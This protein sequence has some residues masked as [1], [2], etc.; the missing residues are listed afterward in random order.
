MALFGFSRLL[1]KNA[2]NFIPLD[3]S[4][5][6]A[7]GRPIYIDQD[8]SRK[9]SGIEQSHITMIL[10]KLKQLGATAAGISSH[11]SV[12]DAHEHMAIIG[13]VR[14]NYKMFQN[15]NEQGKKAGVYITDVDTGSFADGEPGLR[16]VKYTKGVWEL[17]DNS[18]SIIETQY[19]AINGMC[20]DAQQAATEILPDMLKEAYK[21]KKWEGNLQ[22]DGYNMFYNPPSLYTKGIRFKT[23]KQKKT[24]LNATADLLKDTFIQAQTNSKK[25]HW[26]V[27]SDGARLFGK[28]LTKMAGKDLSNHTV[29]FCAPMEDVSD[30]IPKMKQCNINLHD[31]VMKIADDDWRSRRMQMGSGPKI[32]DALKDYPGLNNAN[33]QAKLLARSARKDLLS[34]TGDAMSAG[35][36]GVGIGALCVTGFV[37]AP[38]TGGL[39]LSGVIAGGLGAVAKVKKAEALRNAAATNIKSPGLNP[40]MHPFKS[41]EQMNVHMEEHSGGFVKTFTDVLKA[42]F[43]RG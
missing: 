3:S 33:T 40:H 14:V 28:A 38:L 16:S 26:V 34:I 39:S 18:S 20:R 37:T 27:H 13:S 21:D 30:L 25:V 29:L 19:A 23:P 5:N 42:K 32:R 7:C 8:L 9:F 11:S 12:S 43:S 41:T 10:Q 2:D 15:T 36:I 6:G 31:D 24:S 1:G 35:A 17:K 22:S 4:T